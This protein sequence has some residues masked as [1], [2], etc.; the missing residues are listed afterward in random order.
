MRP[1]NEIKVPLDIAEMSLTEMTSLRKSVEITH[2]IYHYNTSRNKDTEPCVYVYEGG[3]LMHPAEGFKYS[4]Y[5]ERRGES[6]E[7]TPPVVRFNNI[8]EVRA[9]IIALLSLRKKVA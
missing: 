5:F 8:T 3:N 6:D 7:T 4:V 9:F 2:L 1:R